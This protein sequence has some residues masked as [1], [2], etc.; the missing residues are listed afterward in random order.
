MSLM[1]SKEIY[2]IRPGYVEALNLSRR[3]KIEAVKRLEEKRDTQALR[4]ARD[5]LKQVTHEAL[6]AELML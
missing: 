1:F 5:R 2:S 6:R 4:R 3:D